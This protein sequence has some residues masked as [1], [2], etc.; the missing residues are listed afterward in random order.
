MAISV[1]VTRATSPSD[2]QIHHRSRI[3]GHLFFQP[4]S[5]QRRFGLQQR[6]RL[7]LHIRA[8]QGPVGVV[9]FKEGYN[10][11]ATLDQLLGETSIKSTSFGE[12]STVSYW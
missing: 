1:E 11:V 4:R 6:D 5:H 9:I 7:A 2:W 3:V 8:H 12:R 10:A